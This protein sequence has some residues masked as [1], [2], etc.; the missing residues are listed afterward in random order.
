MFNG[1]LN[2]EEISDETLN[3]VFHYLGW[4]SNILSYKHSERPASVII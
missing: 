2:C 3:G 4:M 1:V